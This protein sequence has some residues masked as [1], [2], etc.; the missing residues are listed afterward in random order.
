M[1]KFKQLLY[2]W[3]PVLIWCGLIFWQSSRTLPVVGRTYNQDW[4]IKNL[5]HVLEYFILY[6]FV[7]RSVNWQKE[8]VNY[9]YPLI[10][11]I[12]YGISDEIHQ[13]FVPG[14][15]AWWGDVGFDTLGGLLAGLI[16]RVKYS[17]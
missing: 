10:F 14:R 2:I 11:I 1:M 4:L 15:T 7:F 13:S 5:A 12:L 16:L 3:T 8:K 9:L 17:S 6:I